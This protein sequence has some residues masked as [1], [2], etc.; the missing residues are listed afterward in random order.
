MPLIVYKNQ[1]KYRFSQK[2]FT[3]KKLA[4]AI[5]LPTLV[6]ARAIVKC[7]VWRITL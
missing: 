4:S 3:M 2:R 1:K 6:M 7:G 5:L